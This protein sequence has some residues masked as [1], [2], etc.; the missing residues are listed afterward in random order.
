MEHG[1]YALQA[2]IG[3]PLGAL[4]HRV[5]NA[6]SDA[7]WVPR[8]ETRETFVGLLRE[9]EILAESRRYGS[10][11]RLRDLRTQAERTKVRMLEDRLD[12][13]EI[14]DDLFDYLEATARVMDMFRKP[15]VTLP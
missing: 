8:E 15:R 3:T 10:L 6:R 1:R 5:A 11:E 9:A 13:E 12:Y 2:G 14:L 4:A 7:S